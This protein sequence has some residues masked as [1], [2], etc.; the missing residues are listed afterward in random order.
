MSGSQFQ[1]E[2]EFTLPQ[3][4]VDSNGTLHKDGRMR[5]ATA[6]DEIKPLNDPRVQQNS[7]YLTI[8][9]LSRVITQLGD[10]NTIDTHIIEDL[11]VADLEYLQA[12][13]ERINNRGANVV[14]TTCPECG[15]EF[16]VSA[17]TGAVAETS[18][19]DATGGR[20]ESPAQVD[21]PGM[22][23]RGGGAMGGEGMDVP[24]SAPERSRDVEGDS[25]N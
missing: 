21:L 1:T 14:G 18:P 23:E 2:F 22:D 6:A 9:L 25:G 5:L 4:Y 19:L 8:I 24:E 15:E 10:L 20:S 17:E 7:S 16:D 3:G 13:Y 11:F 12:L